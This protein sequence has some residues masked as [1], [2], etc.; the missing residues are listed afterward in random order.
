MNR[1]ENMYNDAVFVKNRYVR[2]FISEFLLEGNASNNSEDQVVSM[3]SHNKHLNSVYS[4]YEAI[5]KSIIEFWNIDTETEFHKV[6]FLVGLLSNNWEQFICNANDY[7]LRA[8]E[9]ISNIE[10][11]TNYRDFNIQIIDRFINDEYKVADL[12]SFSICA[13]KA[14]SILQELQAIKLKSEEEFVDV[15]KLINGICRLNHQGQAQKSYIYLKHALQT[16]PMELKKHWELFMLALSAT[17]YKK[18]II[19]NLLSD[20]K[21]RKIEIEEIKLWL[22]VFHFYDDLAVYYYLL[23]ARYALERKKEEA[24]EAFSYIL[25]KNALPREWREDVKNLDSYLLGKLHYFSMV[26]NSTLQTLAIEKDA[27]AVS[28]INMFLS[29]DEIG[30]SKAVSAYKAILNAETENLVKLS[31][32]KQLFSFVK[33]PDDLFDIYRQV[34]SKVPNGNKS[35]LSY[36][37]LLI[38]Y[39]CLLICIED[40]ISMDTRMQILLDVFEV[41]EFLNEINKSNPLILERMSEA[42]QSVLEKPGV[43]FDRWVDNK[44]KII[45][46]LRHPAINCSE[47]IIKRFCIPLEE[48]LN[49]VNKCTSEM[50]VLTELVSWRDRWNMQQ[51]CSDYEYAFVRSVDEK[52]KNLKAGANLS[53]S[54]V[55]KTIED[56]SV[57]FCV[58]N[59]AEGSN[60]TVSFN[61]SSEASS[62]SLDVLVAINEG[63]LVSYEGAKFVNIVELRPGDVCGQYYRLHNSLITN[64]KAGDLLTI[65]LRVIV[66]NKIICDSKVK[67]VYKEVG[68]MLVLKDRLYSRITKYE[69]N[70]PAFSKTIKGYG[71]ELEKQLIQQ[72]LEQQLVVIYGPSRVGKSSL[73]NYISNEYIEEYSRNENKGIVAISIA[74]DRHGNDYNVNMIYDDENVSFENAY[75]LLRYLFISPLRIAFG[76]DITLKLKS[77]MRCSIVGEKLNENARKE[78][79]EIIS[80]EGSVRDIL[81]GVSLIL[82]ENNCQV[83]Y[84][85]DEFQQIVEK[86][87]GDTVEFTNICNDIM[88][89]QNSIKLVLCGSDALVRLY[90]C[91]N[92]ENWRGFIQKTADNN[93][94]IGQL[95]PKD[96]KAMMEDASIWGDISEN[97][98]PW[99]PE[100]LNLLYQYTGGNAICGKL[101][102]NE[103]LNKIM[104]GDFNRREKLYPSDITQVAYELLNSE[105][106]LVRNLLVLH[107]TKNLEE[108]IPYLIFI[109]HEL[110]H[111]RNKS[112]VSIRRIREFFAVKSPSAIESALK[113]LIAR[114]ILKV[115]EE[116]QR[117]GFSTMFY[118]DFFRSQATEVRLHEVSIQLQ[119]E[120]KQDNEEM[121]MDPMSLQY[122][123]QYFKEAAPEV[124]NEFL[125]GLAINA[126]DKEALKSLLGT[127]QSG[128]I[129]NG[130]T[131]INH[132]NIQSIT[133]TLNEIITANDRT[134]L[135][136]GIQELPRLSNYLPQL[137][138]NA[139]EV[140]VSEDSI[141]RAMDNYVADM[142]ESL[143]SITL[144]SPRAGDDFAEATINSGYNTSISSS[145]AAVLGVSDDEYEEF[146]EQYNLPEFFL[147][148]LGFAHQL[149]ELFMRG[150]VGDD[151]D[152]IDFSPV[153]IMYCKL[154]E[155]LLKEYHISIYGNS[156]ES[157]DTDMRKPENKDEKY[158]WKDIITLPV[159]QQQRLTIGSF[160]F[161]LY[162]KWAIDKLVKVTGKKTDEWVEH[163]KMIMAVKDIRNPSAHGNKDHRISL[164]QKN[165]ITEMLLEKHGFMRLI[166]LA[167]G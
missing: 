137:L 79:E 29:K 102:G 62:A 40:G 10:D 55:N 143:E 22:P 77:R 11:Q 12:S 38:E 154:I 60:S 103:L 117:Y 56:F 165:A 86:W 104:R 81:A 101:F 42:E 98:S 70:V 166:E 18:T 23:A 46:I 133:N 112:D 15:K 100:A 44:D 156:F 114:G 59:K 87:R 28:F 129:F 164:E 95:S 53:V 24:T 88:N 41:F 105:V 69:T 147:R 136:K 138:D 80:A 61:N 159:T 47:D 97:N 20:V 25:D 26:N 108:E 17:S 54:V 123:R 134:V 65:V 14:Y 120:R 126:K 106:G 151:I 78:I 141:S 96:F 144:Q 45:S 150:A 6:I 91:E 113:V 128:N 30:I 163:K 32:Y 152:K 107:N 119:A 13:S 33:K 125:A 127:S 149:D 8:L 63:A 85:F 110:I 7:D 145:Y 75:E 148:S 82:E 84:L 5:K 130:K 68:N 167:L 52:I 132:V 140:D 58:E 135:I 122:I 111:D 36:N 124:Q 116:K 74:D 21:K 1:D 57:F 71:R 51:N 64:I 146:M 157:L 37:E 73:V 35:R 139:G 43:A 9:L 16:Y 19:I 3:M 118:F 153:T 161:P 131:T 31:S 160:V 48:C 109:A 155:S 89:Y 39:G 27:E 92:D 76:S 83:W 49:I 2:I 158:K 99:S 115:N 162:K 34:E 67:Y 72:Y 93:V 94:P 50:Q 90:N 142:E 4:D 121:S 66:E